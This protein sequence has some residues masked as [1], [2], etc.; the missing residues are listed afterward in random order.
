MLAFSSLLYELTREVHLL[1]S[2]PGRESC[3]LCCSS[4]EPAIAAASSCFVLST[5]AFPWTLRLLRL[6]VLRSLSEGK[7]QLDLV[8]L[9]LYSLTNR[10]RRD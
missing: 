9:S 3:S 8:L 10:E 1:S 2:H 6:I 5:L 7:E 4:L